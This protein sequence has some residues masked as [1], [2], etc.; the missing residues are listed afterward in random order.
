MTATP[1][2]TPDA[3]D[4]E[5]VEGEET[6][7]GAD[8]RPIPRAAAVIATDHPV[9]RVSWRDGGSDA[10]DLSGWIAL[11]HLSSLADKKN[12]AEASVVDDGLT[13]RWGDD[14][15]PYLSTYLLASIAEKQRPFGPDDIQAWQERLRLSSREAAT[16]LGVGLS[17][18]HTYKRGKSKIPVALAVAC[19]AMEADPAA[20]AA[21]F[22]PS[23]PAGRPSLRHI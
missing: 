5:P 15:G 6:V 18:W 7:F 21:Q 10:V 22:K 12:F 4:W 8:P 20:L 3:F 14:D 23:P 17:T 13:V 16:M 11:N 1:A 2:D 9:L 19:R